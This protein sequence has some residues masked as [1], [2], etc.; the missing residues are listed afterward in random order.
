[1]D[2]GP[3]PT[4]LLQAKSSRPLAVQLDSLGDRNNYALKRLLQLRDRATLQKYRIAEGNEPFDL[5]LFV[6]IGHVGVDK[7]LRSAKRAGPAFVFSECDWPYPFMPGV[8]CSLTKSFPWARSWSFLLANEHAAQRDGDAP[9]YLFSFIGRL[10]THPCR[11]RVRAL[12]S[13]T[14][15]CLDTSEAAGHFPG[16]D[17]SEGYRRLMWNSAFVLCPR[18]FGAS[19]IRIFEAMQMGRV[20]VVIGD[21]WVP[22]PLA[23]WSS[24]SIRVREADIAGIPTILRE[25]APMALEM[26]MRARQTFEQL[27]APSIFLERL[28]DFCIDEL[29]LGGRLSHVARGARAFSTREI[30]EILYPAKV[31][32]KRLVNR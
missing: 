17:Y 8:Y 20:P 3:L 19:S 2:P 15:P 28:L 16:W 31:R 4:S 9:E 22:P 1:M 18:G 11:A 7:L 12:H 30:R 21:A 29:P 23:D 5:T 14:M 27:Y 26:G 10:A 24:F 6:E 25:R 13:P 32:L